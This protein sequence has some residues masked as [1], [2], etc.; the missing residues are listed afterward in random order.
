MIFRG[1]TRC[2]SVRSFSRS[3]IPWFATKKGCGDLFTAE[4]LRLHLH[5][6]DATCSELNNLLEGRYESK[7]SL[8]ELIVNTAS[9]RAGSSEYAIHALASSH[10]NHSFFWQ[11]LT[12]TPK[13]MTVALAGALEKDFGSVEAF[14][15]SF[16][17]HAVHLHGA[18]W[19]FLVYNRH[20]QHMSIMALQDSGTP[21]ALGLDV[22]L[23]VDVWEH[24]YLK[25]FSGARSLY[26][27][28]L[29]RHLNWEF[30]TE[31]LSRAAQPPAAAQGFGSAV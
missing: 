2:S 21:A 29:L 3:A 23:A 24:A 28:T 11:C 30:V 18:G 4:Q 26:I 14:I 10:F 1:T 22:L 6:H 31:N 12:P 8:G 25:D 9:S 16:A 17:E 20:E 27:T 7:F 13:P 15:S 5:H 19:V